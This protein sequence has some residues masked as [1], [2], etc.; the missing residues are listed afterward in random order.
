MNRDYPLSPTPE[1]KKDSI[2]VAKEK[3]GYYAKK[4]FARKDFLTNIESP[5]AD[6]SDKYANIV[7]NATKNMSKKD[8][9]KKGVN[10]SISSKGDTTL[11][12]NSKNINFKKK[13][14]KK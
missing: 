8:L 14:G 11:S 3:A 4:N 1:P 6:S 12:F 5:V 10:R 2:D 13:Y 9:A 7:F